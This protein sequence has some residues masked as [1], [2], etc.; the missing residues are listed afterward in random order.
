MPA[1]PGKAALDADLAHAAAVGPIAAVRLTVVTRA[2]V[3]SGLTR[4]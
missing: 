2:T 1:S 3:D 4:C